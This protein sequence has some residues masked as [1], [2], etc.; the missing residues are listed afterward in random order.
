MLIGS[1]G[2]LLGGCSTR[3]ELRVLDVA[4]TLTPG[5]GGVHRVAAGKAFGPDP[6]QRLDVYAPKHM[7]RPAPVVLFS[8]GGNWTFGDREGYAFVGEA[9]GSR[10]FVTVVA[11]YRLVPAFRYPA[12]VQ[13]AALAV[14]WTVDNIAGHGGDPRRLGLCGHSAGAYNVAMVALD[15]HW[16]RQVQVDPAVVRALATLAGPFDFYPFDSP[17]S[18]EA[19]EG[20]PNPQATQPITFVRADA[21]PAFLAA[22]VNDRY[23]KPGNSVRMGEALRRAGASAEVKLYPGLNHTDI[24]LALSKPFRGKAPVLADMT[25]FLHAE[26]V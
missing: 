12:F 9:L 24:V 21:P 7:D 14:R 1:A 22:G 23:V 25:G 20:T 8:Y 26:L 3:D 13:D 17:I 5:D 4:N 15:E 18:R 6:R 2:A 11:D 10:G 16:L 19:F